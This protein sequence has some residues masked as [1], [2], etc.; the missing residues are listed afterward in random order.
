MSEKRKKAI[1]LK[2][3]SR[4][5]KATSTED[6]SEALERLNTRAYGQYAISELA[7]SIPR[8][9]KPNS[10]KDPEVAKQY[11]E[12][13]FVSYLA[14]RISYAEYVFF[15]SRWVEGIHED[16]WLSGSYT[17][18]L[19]IQERIDGLN[20]KLGLSTDKYWPKG[21]EL[22]EYRKLNKEY[23]A[24]LDS[25][26]IQ[27]L[28]EFGLKELAVL[29]EQ[30][31]KE[32]ESLRERGRRAVFHKKDTVE[33][34]REVVLHYEEEARKAAQAQAYSAAIVALG[35]GLEGILILRCLKSKKKAI[36]TASS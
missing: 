27:A 9:R 35:S 10:W 16:R 29:N 26:F 14:R 32:F 30:N 23:D 18:V 5:K 3:L 25:L 21:D 15:A 36:Q 20:R 7:S 2:P 22:K 12:V 17:E 31:P 28:R 13:S 4:N 8:K 24:L 11:I 1:R 34:L 33:A 19:K 6:L